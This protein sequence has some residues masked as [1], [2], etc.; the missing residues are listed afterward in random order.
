V[1]VLTIADKQKTSASTENDSIK[2]LITCFS[3]LLMSSLNQVFIE[4]LVIYSWANFREWS[5]TIGWIKYLSYL[6]GLCT[7]EICL[8]L[9]VR[10]FRKN[11]RNQL[12]SL[13]PCNFDSS[14]LVVDISASNRICQM[15]P[16]KSLGHNIATDK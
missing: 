7:E 2:I 16:H 11:I 10:D 15:Y 6:L 12:S 8:A 9:L 5:I 3:C 13:I 14:N 4:W 1:H